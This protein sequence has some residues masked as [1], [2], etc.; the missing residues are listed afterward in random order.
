MILR[1]GEVVSDDNVDGR[2]ETRPMEAIP[3]PNQDG[4]DDDG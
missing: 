1:V 4:D 3:W 2:A